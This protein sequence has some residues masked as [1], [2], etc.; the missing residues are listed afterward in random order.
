MKLQPYCSRRMQRVGL[1]QLAA[2][3]AAGVLAG[4]VYASDFDEQ[5]ATHFEA[6]RTRDLQKLKS[7]LT[8]EENLELIL[9]GGKRT[10]TKAEFVAFH[11]DWFA[12]KTW[13][14]RFE[15]ISRIETAN[16]AVATV[17]THYE[18]VQDGKP[19]VSENWLTLIFR[20]EDGRWALVHDQNTRALEH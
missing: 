6:V 10:T 19:Y 15:P 1:F 2:L 18:D 4:Q 12:S 20:N 3:A 14:M 11:V 17:R 16:M 5:L 7:T 9:P 13:T 8:A